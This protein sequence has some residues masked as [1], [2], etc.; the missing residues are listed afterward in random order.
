M[1]RPSFFLKVNTHLWSN[2]NERLPIVPRLPL[3]L[4]NMARTLPTVRVVLS[5]AASTNMA[6]PWGPYPS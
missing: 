3:N 1:S 5:V 2:R 4:L 6:M